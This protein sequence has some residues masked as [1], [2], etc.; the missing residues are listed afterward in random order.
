MLH[1]CLLNEYMKYYSYNLVGAYQV[2]SS[3][4][5]SLYKES[6]FI[7]QCCEVDITMLYL[8]RR[9]TSLNPEIQNLSFQI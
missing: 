4:P 2:P 7:K 1:G 5:A 9:K 8:K 3:V 6:Q